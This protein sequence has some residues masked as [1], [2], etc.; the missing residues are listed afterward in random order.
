MF[1]TI[2]A[3]LETVLPHRPPEA[4]PPMRRLGDDS[5]GTMCGSTAATRVPVAEARWLVPTP[6]CPIARGPDSS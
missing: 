6:Q 2:D 4:Q 3:S 1:W 5:G